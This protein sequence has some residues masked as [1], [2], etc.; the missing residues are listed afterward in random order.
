MRAALFKWRDVKTLQK[1]ST[2]LTKM[3][4]TS[5]TWKHQKMKSE[6]IK[7]IHKMKCIKQK[8]RSTR[9]LRTNKNA[10][11]EIWTRQKNT[12]HIKGPRK[13]RQILEYTEK[14]TWNTYL[15]HNA[16]HCNTLQHIAWGPEKRGK[17]LIL[18]KTRHGK[19]I[20]LQ[21]NVAHCNTL[22]HT[23][24]HWRSPEKRGRCLNILK[25]IF[26][27]CIKLL[28]YVRGR[29]IKLQHDVAH[30]NTLQNTATHCNTLKEPRKERQMLEY[31]PDYIWNVYQTAT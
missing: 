16:V 3:H 1:N 7:R 26:G 28:H 6:Y 13:E 11:N 31:T 17:S 24:T 23:A 27:T 8:I 9:D 25:P 29:Y 19:C 21:H 10:W 5:D 12:R 20:K 18:L 2:H 15:Q 4:E 22:Q 14:I 30:C